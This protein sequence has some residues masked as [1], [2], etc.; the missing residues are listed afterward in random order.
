[1]GEAFEASL[2]GARAFAV[3]ELRAR[4]FFVWACFLAW[5]GLVLPPEAAP[6][7][8]AEGIEGPLDVFEG[9]V[10]GLMSGVVFTTGFSGDFRAVFRPRSDA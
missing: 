3:F 7:S 10:S 6:L 9:D 4:S 1:L 2:F 8:D 5:A